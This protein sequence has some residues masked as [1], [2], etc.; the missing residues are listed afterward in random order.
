MQ[1]VLQYYMPKILSSNILKKFRLEKQKYFV[2]SSHRE[3][4]LDNDERF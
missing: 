4:N 3:E 2:F 1:E